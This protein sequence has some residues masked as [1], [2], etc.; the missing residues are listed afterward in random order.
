[1]ILMGLKSYIKRGIT[2]ITKGV[3]NKIVKV[4][5]AQIEYGG[6]LKGKKVLITGGSRGLGFEIAKKCLHE[7]ALVTITGRKMETLQEAKEKLGNPENLFLVEHD[8]TKYETDDDAV[9]QARKAMGGIDILVN[10]AGVSVHNIDYS[11]CTEDMWD[12]QMDTNLKG[13]YFFTQAFMKYYNEVGKNS[14]NIIN[15]VSERGMYG[16]DVPYGLAK[17]AL[18]SYTEGMAK[19]LILKGIRVNAIAPGVTATEM[20]GYDPEGNLF[21][22]YTR[23][24]R[25]FLAEEIAEVAVFLMTDA[26]NCISGQVIVC[27]E[28]N[29]LR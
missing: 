8:I 12:Y 27:N 22:P 23:G 14:G 7:Q 6:V 13:T 10:N 4:N 2:Y 5:I 26:S 9:Y 1:M 3:P 24:R 29:T 18:I 15:M 25:V 20:T 11:S 19:K 28:G 17:R 21:R 16:D